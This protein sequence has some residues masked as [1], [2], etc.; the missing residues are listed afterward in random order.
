MDWNCTLTEERLSDFLE[1]ALLP[2]EA[3][4]FSAHAA[5][6]ANCTKL[7]AQ[8]SGLVSRMQDVPQ[9][10]EPA[11]L[12]RKILDATLGPRKQK[13]AAQGWFG[14]LPLIWQP[15]FAMGIVTVAASFVIVFHAASRIGVQ[16]QPESRESGSRRKSP[17][18]SYLRAQE[19][20]S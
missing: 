8:V 17:G 9:V 11:Q 18:A 10:E 15:R 5:G 16:D 19:P 12:R 14:W 20:N 2:E 3:A 6:C 1:G 4:A 7:V 13:P